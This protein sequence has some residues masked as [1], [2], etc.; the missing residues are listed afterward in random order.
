MTLVPVIEQSGG[1]AIV[2]TALSDAVTA[3]VPRVPVTV[4]VL[5]MVPAPVSTN[6]RLVVKLSPELM[7]GKLT[8]TSSLVLPGVPLSST[9]LTSLSENA[10]QLL[11]TYVYVTGAEGHTLVLSGVFVTSIQQ[12]PNRPI[13]KSDS[14]ALIV[15]DERVSAMELAKHTSPGANRVML[16]APSKKVPGGNV[17]GEPDLGVYGHE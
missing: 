11:T 8:R 14:V 13:A 10:P 15:D 3:V 9:S 16:M 4:T 7:A 6:V 5:V 2:T 1:A 12:V 17:L